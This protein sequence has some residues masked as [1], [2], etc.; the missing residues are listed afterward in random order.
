MQRLKSAATDAQRRANDAF[1]IASRNIA[2]SA[3]IK[4][5]PL[6]TTRAYKKPQADFI[7]SKALALETEC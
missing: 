6:N 1:L 7:A 5:Q 3:S 2:I 4:G